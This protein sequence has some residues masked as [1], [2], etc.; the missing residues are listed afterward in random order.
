MYT[1]NVRLKAKDKKMHLDWDS[2]LR[3]DELFNEA[4]DREEVRQLLE[5]ESSFS[6]QYV[7]R[8]D[9]FHDND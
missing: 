2:E 1:V 4:D 7:D 8:F 5:V 6:T 9:G 3:V